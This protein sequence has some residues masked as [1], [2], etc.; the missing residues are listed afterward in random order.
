MSNQHKKNCVICRNNIREEMQYALKQVGKRSIIMDAA[1]VFMLNEWLDNRKEDEKQPA[2][3]HVEPEE[4]QKLVLAYGVLIP[5]Y[6]S[7]IENW[8]EELNRWKEYAFGTL[9]DGKLKLS[10]YREFRLFEDQ[11]IYKTHIPCALLMNT[12]LDL[13]KEREF[14]FGYTA[15][16]VFGGWEIFDNILNRDFIFCLGGIEDSFNGE[17]LSN[18]TRYINVEKMMDIAKRLF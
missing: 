11:I 3:P 12:S 16:L 4:N 13:K 7:D 17:D 2:F 14:G 1:E 15:F 18:W 9:E 10:E 6:D 8:A 5:Q